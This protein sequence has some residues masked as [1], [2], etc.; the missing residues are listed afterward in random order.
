MKTVQRTPIHLYTLY[1]ESL[2]V[3]VLHNWL[4]D[5]HVRFFSLALSLHVYYIHIII[6]IIFFLKDLRV[7][8][9]HQGP[10]PQTSV[11]IS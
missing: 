2:I 6:H 7:S 5:L 4:C 3:N 8:H 1:P 11:H 10:L 9:I